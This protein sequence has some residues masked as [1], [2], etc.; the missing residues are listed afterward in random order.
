MLLI[1]NSKYTICTL[2]I[3]EGNGTPLH[4]PCLENPT[5]RGDLWATVHMVAKNRT[6]LKWRSMHTH[7]IC[8]IYYYSQD[9]A[10]THKVDLSHFTEAYIIWTLHQPGPMMHMRYANHIRLYHHAQRMSIL[11]C[12]CTEGIWVYAWVHHFYVVC[13]FPE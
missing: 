3:G 4:Y 1:R 6:W 13:D 10:I 2:Y 5:D 9:T 7:W 12:I 11:Q 8:L